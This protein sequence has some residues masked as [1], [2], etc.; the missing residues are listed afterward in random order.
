MYMRAVFGFMF[1]C[2]SS[3]CFHYMHRLRFKPQSRTES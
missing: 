2:L 3:L 1:Q